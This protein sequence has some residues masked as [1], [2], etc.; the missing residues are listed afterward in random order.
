M[1]GCHRTF[2]NTWSNLELP[3]PKAH[4]LPST[5]WRLSI[6]L[7]ALWQCLTSNNKA[8]H[9]Y[10]LG[11]S[12]SSYRLCGQPSMSAR[13]FLSVTYCG[14]I[15]I[16]I[17]RVRCVFVGWTVTKSILGMSYLKPAGASCF[18]HNVAT[19]TTGSLPFCYRIATSRWTS[20]K[21]TNAFKLQ[22]YNDSIDVLTWVTYLVLRCNL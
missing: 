17:Y 15:Y 12:I 9:C 22:F 7:F 8:L 13:K 19:R 10:K 18:E 5:H 4:A 3:A 21:N 1:L 14:C 2:T 6:V 16:Y 20:W 11:S